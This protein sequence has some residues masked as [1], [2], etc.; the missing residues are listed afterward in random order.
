[1]S[2]QTSALGDTAH[3]SFVPNGASSSS[4]IEAVAAATIAVCQQRGML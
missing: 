2:W 3:R 4:S 1:M